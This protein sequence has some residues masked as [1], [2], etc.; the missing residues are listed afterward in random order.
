VNHRVVAVALLLLA[1][2]PTPSQVIAFVAIEPALSE[3]TARL[4]VRV[5]AP[6]A[7]PTCAGGYERTRALEDTPLPARIPI[8]PPASLGDRYW[9]EATALGS[10]DE[11]LATVRAEGGFTEG[12]VR[13]I[14][15]LLE[16]ACAGTECSPQRSCA[17]GVCGDLCVTDDPLADGRGAPSARVRCS[18]ERPDGG[19]SC[20]CPCGD[21]TCVDG[22]CVPAVALR[23]LAAGTDHTCA[24]SDDAVYCWGN[25]RWGQLGLGEGESVGTPTRVGLSL[26]A[27][28]GHLEAGDRNTCVVSGGQLHCWGDASDGRLGVEGDAATPVRIGETMSVEWARVSQSTSHTCGLT[29]GGRVFCWGRADVGQIGVFSEPLPESVTEPQRVGGMFTDIVVGW[30]F[31]C[32]LTL[33]GSVQCW[34]ANGSGQVGQPSEVPRVT[35]PTSVDAQRYAQLSAEEHRICGLWQSGEVHCWGVNTGNRSGLEEPADRNVY[36]P[37][38]VDADL[39]FRRLSIGQEHSCAIT[40]DGLLSCWGFNV[41]GQLGLG[42]VAPRLTPTMVGD[43]TDW[44]A[45]DAG[46]FHTCAAKTDG[47]VFCWGLGTS[48]QLGD[49]CGLAGVDAP[50]RVCF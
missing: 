11:V 12:S 28:V 17:G 41:H 3:D 15:L 26:D 19:V 8:G 29:L 23:H 39:S 33:T 27:A 2:E 31:A 22:Q 36:T 37:T 48:R 25:N 34:G 14:R 16:A 21:D 4:R 20:D 5:C 43:E 32:G 45:I 42:D 49:A 44:A 30:S 18:D 46:R 40:S 7:A 35:S 50:C 13:E 38:P 10:G 1:C 9:I 6:D 24:A 47:R